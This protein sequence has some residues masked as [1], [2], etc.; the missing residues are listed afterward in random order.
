MKP[1]GRLCRA[2]RARRVAWL[3]VGWSS[4]VAAAAPQGDAPVRILIDQPP[5]AVEYQL[6]RLTNEELT[7]VERRE[8]PKYRLVYVALLTRKGLGRSL[9]DEGLTALV[10]IDRAT[11]TQ[12]LLEALAK[13]PTEDVPTAN[14]VAA[15]LVGQPVETLRSQRDGLT[16]ATGASTVSPALRAAYT[17]LMIA[18]DSADAPWQAAGQRTGHLAEFLN[19]V[20]LLPTDAAFDQLRVRLSASIAALLLSPLPAVD[21]DT[22]AAAVRALLGLPERAWPP[23]DVERLARAMI[24]LVRDLAPDQRTEPNAAEAIQLA[25]RLAASLPEA[26]RTVLRR[27]LRALGVQVVKIETLPEQMQFT[28]KWFAVERGKPVQIVFVNPDAMPHNLVFGRPGSLEKLGTAAMTMQMPADQAVKPYVP[29]G[30][31]VLQATTLVREGETERLNFTA[32]ADV[33][34]YVFACTFPGHWVRMYG[35]M[36]VVDNLEAWE[37]APTTPTDPITSRPFTSRR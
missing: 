27:D 16:R 37:A 6:G 10:K 7:R 1:L 13:I 2:A 30:P 23:S 19:G 4:I 28:V 14:A 31:L 20:P 36:L 9:R 35:V 3:L 15:M 29:A 18:D 17:A 22:R 8:E 26:A 33:G 24:A 12:I 32:P 25:E 21:A 11:P 5:R 34:E